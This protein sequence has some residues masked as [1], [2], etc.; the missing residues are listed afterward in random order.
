M[1]QMQAQLDKLLAQIGTGMRMEEIMRN[2]ET[3]AGRRVVK[4]GDEPWLPAADWDSTNV[5]SVD[6][7]TV[8]LIAIW[9]PT[10]GQGAFRRLIAAIEAAGLRPCIVEPTVEM[11]ATLKRWGWKGKRHGHGFGSEE[12]WRPARR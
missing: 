11:R 12:R 2:D 5:V 6:G 10:P 4:P 7:D 8:R 3:A 9:T 1:S